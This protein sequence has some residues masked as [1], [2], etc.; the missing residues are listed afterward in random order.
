MNDWY[1]NLKLVYEVEGICGDCGEEIEEARY[2]TQN[3]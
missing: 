1:K 3:I 2:F